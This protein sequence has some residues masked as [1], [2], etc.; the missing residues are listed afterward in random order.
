MELALENLKW[1]CVAHAVLADEVLGEVARLLHE[2]WP[3]PEWPQERILKTIQT[4]NDQQKYRILAWQDQRLVGHATFLPGVIATNRGTLSIMQFAGVCV[5][6]KLRGRQIGRKVVE[7][8]F[9]KVGQPG[10]DVALFQTDVPG[11]YEKLRRL[12]F[13]TLCRY[14]DRVGDKV[15]KTGNVL[16]CAPGGPGPCPGELHVVA[17]A[18]G[19]GRRG[20]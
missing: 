6:A 19:R 4:M 8:A 2:T 15:A 14:A 7:W 16:H 5:C 20:L 1:Q 11:F 18:V 3:D 9:E 10:F 13:S 12:L 17:R